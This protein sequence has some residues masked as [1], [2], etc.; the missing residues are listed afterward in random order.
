M[1]AE[2]VKRAGLPFEAIPA[3][4]VHGVGLRALPG[5]LLQLARGYFS[6]LAIMRRLKPDAYFFT[7]G[8]VAVPMAL[9][10]LRRP[11]LAFVPDIQPGLAL[12]AIGRLSDV[13]AVTAQESVRRY[14]ARK[15]VVVTGYPV[16]RELVPQEKPPARRALG[17]D[18]AAPT[19]LVF[20]GSLGARSI[21]QALWAC[22]DELLETAQVIHLTGSLDW[23]RVAALRQTLPEALRGRYLAHE[24]LHEQ[25]ALALSAADLVVSRAGASAL[26][27]YPRFGLPAVLVPYPHAW[28]YQLVNAKY[29]AGRGAA[30]VLADERLKH[31]LLSTVVDLLADPRRLSAMSAAMKALDRPGAAE[32]L[33]DEIV[34]LAEGEAG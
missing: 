6:S 5:N 11:Q 31:D 12:R 34:R 16:R 15:R 30:L 17:L 18:E 22:L 10:S 3:A 13:V 26:G 4:G 24:Y 23:P 8:Y 29:L 25:M 1:E 14:P 33:A 9:A 21:N 2:L 27:E 28:R 7:G 32:A 20:G 19:A